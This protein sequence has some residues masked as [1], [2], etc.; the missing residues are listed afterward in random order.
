ML[1]MHTY[2]HVYIYIHIYLD[3]HVTFLM[4]FHFHTCKYIEIY[5]IYAYANMQYSSLS[6]IVIAQLLFPPSLHM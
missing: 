3:A 1:Y 6:N 4:N 5:M 2:I